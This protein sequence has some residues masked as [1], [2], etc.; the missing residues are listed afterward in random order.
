MLYYYDEERHEYF[1]DGIQ[2][3]SVT[4]IASPISFERL[5]ALQKALVERARLRASRCHEIVEEYLIT[6]EIDWESVE[7]DYRPYIEQFVLWRRTYRPKVLFTEKRLFSDEF[8]GTCDLLCVI[9]GKVVLV[10][11]KFTATADKKSLAVQLEG[12]KRLLAKY[13]INVDECY[14]LHIK[15]DGFV[16]K[17]IETDSEW[18]DL[19]LRHN[20]KM[21]EKR[22]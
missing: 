18:F 15:K 14:Y 20:K 3:P 16:F 5:D 11:Y 4:D 2:K 21:K 19:L 7:S 1:V 22:K 6:D 12:Y 13:G 17:P 9:D 8:C 10:D